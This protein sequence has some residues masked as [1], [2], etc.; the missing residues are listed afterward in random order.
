MYQE[1]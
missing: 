1:L